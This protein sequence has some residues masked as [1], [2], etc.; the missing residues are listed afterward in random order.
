MANLLESYKNRLA[1]SESVYQK[2]HNGAKMSSQK[3]LMIASVLNNTAKFMNEAFTSGDATQRGAL[4]DYKR[5]CLNIST[6]ALPNLILPELMLT[7]PMSSI[8]GYVTYLRY[9]AGTAKGGVGAGDTFNSVYRLGEMTPDRVD[10]TKDRVVE[11][12][13]EETQKVAWTP[14]KVD[15]GFKFLD[16]TGKEVT[17]GTLAEDGT[18]T[19][20]AGATKVA[21][22]YDNV[23]IPQNKI[24]TLKAEMDVI[25]LHAHARRIAVYYS[26]IAAFQAKTDYGTDIG[27]QLAAQ[28][29]G[30]LA[31]EI[32]TE[33][34]M[35]LYNGAEHDK[36]I[37]FVSYDKSKQ[38]NII[39]RSQ[40]Y[41]YFNEIIARAKQVLY[42]RTQK[43]AP[44]YMVVGTDVIS[45]LPYLK[46][47][48]AAPASAINGP[49]FAG[50]VDGLKVFVSPSIEANEY[51]FGVN[52]SDLQTS[53][54]VYAPYMAIVPTQ[55]LGF[56]DGTMSQGFSTMYDM[57][58]LSTY[59]GTWEDPT[60]IK[61]SKD[62]KHSHLLVKGVFDNV[63][64]N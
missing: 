49:Y 2:S 64:D 38:A 63:I 8:A 57:K 23:I 14:V 33:G 21:Y 60:T 28:A 39:S 24:P 4:G 59:E 1:I 51:F 5:F 25:E 47:W 19:V 29:Q 27:E 34:V 55:L 50:S 54:A 10:Y 42:K 40:Y 43:F 13:T 52:G 6:V 58:L 44:N 31:Y 15:E 17:G 16:N 11:A 56:A 12:I 32:D 45:I 9:T 46:G 53:A 48:N 62:G 41:E 22:V 3:K 7:Q 35:M 30:E 18:V 37:D 36:D 20:P 26:Q 61:D